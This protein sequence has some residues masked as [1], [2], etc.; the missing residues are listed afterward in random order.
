MDMKAAVV[1][2]CL[3]D[4]EYV[5]TLLNEWA[6]EKGKSVQTEIF[7]SSEAFLFQYED[8]KTFD[9][10]ILDIEM[11]QMDGVTLAKKL[12]KDNETVQIVFV[13]GY[14][15]YIAEGY[16]VA[17][18]HYLVKPL[19][20]QKFFDVLDRAA[21]KLIQN[22]RF[23]SVELSGQRIRIPF[24]EIIYLDVHQN[25]VTIH[26]KEDITVKKTLSE[27]EKQLDER[28]FRAGRSLILNLSRIQ[29]VTRSQVT[30]TG[31]TA[32]PLPRGVYD[33]LNRAII[34][35]M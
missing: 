15:E 29:R 17:A 12:R 23:L 26:A 5:K 8:D 30:L 21:Q 24:Y 18:L 13:S 6:K 25:Y 20:P 35:R 14:G 3:K 7:P 1:D 10:L 22:E 27:F 28:F 33:E 11:A 31:G 32:L 19:Q 16:E 4:A 2:D 34:E 9:L